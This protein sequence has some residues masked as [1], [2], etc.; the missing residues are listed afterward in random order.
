MRF[1]IIFLALLVSACVTHPPPPPA[2]E[3]QIATTGIPFTDVYA[4][5]PPVKYMRPRRWA[6]L[7]EP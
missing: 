2:F 1:V 6:S 5:R 3:K 7:G 4:G